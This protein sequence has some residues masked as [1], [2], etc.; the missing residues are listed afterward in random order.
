MNESQK[1]IMKEKMGKKGHYYVFEI[2]MA[3]NGSLYLL[4]LEHRISKGKKA[5]NSF[6]IF[7]DQLYDFKYLLESAI[8][9]MEEFHNGNTES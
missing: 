7:E 3:D 1:T 2:K 9:G 8:A 6:V 5:F 4:V